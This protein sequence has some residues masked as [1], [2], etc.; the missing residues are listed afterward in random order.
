MRIAVV[1]AAG[2]VT[3]ALSG[4]ARA[5][6]HD[7]AI[8]AG[9]D[10]VQVLDARSLDE[11]LRSVDVVVD[12]LRSPSLDETESSV[13][14]AW[15]ARR[16]GEAALRAGV[17]RTVVI[18]LIGADAISAAEEGAGTGLDGFY[19]AKYV[20]EQATLFHAPGARVVRSAQ[21]HDVA[22]G[23]V[24]GTTG[25]DRTMVP[26]LLIQPVAVDALVEVVLGA[27]TGES[28]DEV[29]EV[30]G[31]RPER[32][33]RMAAALAHRMGSDV[34]VVPTRVGRLA[35]AGVLLP[36]RGALLVGPTFD[37]WLDG[38]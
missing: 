7:V 21:L 1:G 12:V 15:A 34:V 29:V 10:G 36:R 2:L 9:A 33:P 3:R 35:R 30:A 6:G 27:A 8:L 24:G 28:D 37:S 23:W 4:A 18:S 16:L 13:F 38:R 17:R 26:D 31:P 11:S 19:C 14:Y 25:G 20:H 5:E 22:R 32:L